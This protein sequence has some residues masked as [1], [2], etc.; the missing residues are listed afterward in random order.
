MTIGKIPNN[1]LTLAD[2]PD[3]DTDWGYIGEFALSFDGYEYWGSF[4]KCAEIANSKKDDSL[5]DL[6]TCLF[7]E[8]RSWWHIGEAPSEK[9]MEYIRGVVEKIRGR[10][11]ANDKR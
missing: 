5:T 11:A 7:F 1:K 10:V 9:G 6:R 8:Q 3:P 4:E 2:I